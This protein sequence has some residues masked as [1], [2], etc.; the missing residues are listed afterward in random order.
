MLK[1]L[2]GKKRKALDKKQSKLLFLLYF[3]TAYR[4]SY[5]YCGNKYIAEEAAQEAILK[6]IQNIEQLIDPDKIESW[7]KRI[8]VNNTIDIMRK[9]EKLVSLDNLLPISDPAENSPEYIIDSQET[10]DAISRAI[11][12]LNPA[13]KQVIHL[14]YYEEMKM[15][16]IS[17]LL[18]KPEGTI[19]SMI[20]RGK[21]IIKKKLVEEGHLESTDSKGGIK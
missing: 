16:D 20:H 7:I 8:A 5:F 9:H 21:M 12:S 2:F 17:L 4:T 18:N 1:N 15:K 14:R 19:K 10:V 6:A 3:K 11:D 13:M